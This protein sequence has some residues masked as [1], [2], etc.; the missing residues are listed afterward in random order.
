VT[1]QDA[2]A[3]GPGNDIPGSAGEPPS[4]DI[5]VAHPARVYDYWLGGCFL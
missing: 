5:T 3:G 1:S 4:F 2:A